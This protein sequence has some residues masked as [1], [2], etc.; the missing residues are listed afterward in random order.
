MREKSKSGGGG[1]ASLRRSASSTASD[2]V[3]KAF[4][5]ADVASVRTSLDHGVPADVMLPG[6]SALGHAAQEGHLE[7]VRLL[8]NRGANVNLAYGP[9]G[10]GTALMQACQGAQTAVVRLLIESRASIVLKTGDTILSNLIETSSETNEYLIPARSLQEVNDARTAIAKLLMGAPSSRAA[11]VE[12]HISPIGKYSVSDALYCAS[13][14]GWLWMV[15]LVLKHK[16]DV[17]YA[18]QNGA[19]PLYIACKAGMTDCASALV[20]AGA[21]P[22][23]LKAGGW[24]PLLLAVQSNHVGCVRVLIEARADLDHRIDPQEGVTTCAVMHACIA[25]TGHYESLELLLA[26]RADPDRA[27]LQTSQP[28]TALFNACHNGFKHLAVLLESYGARRH[29]LHTFPDGRVIDVDQTSDARDRGHDELSDWLLDTSDWV[30]PLHFWPMV[31]LA[32]TRAL[33]RDGWDVF[34]SLEL[35]ALWQD[36]RR[37]CHPV[38]MADAR[39]WLAGERVA[40]LWPSQADPPRPGE[41]SAV[42]AMVNEAHV[43]EAATLLVE[44]YEW[45]PRSH[46][47]FPP[48]M[49]ARAC[50]LLWLGHLLARTLENR[51]EAAAAA[52][53]AMDPASVTA[54]AL[55]PCFSAVALLDAWRDH[56]MPHALRRDE[57]GT[58]IWYCPQ[59]LPADGN[60]QR[61]SYALYKSSRRPARWLPG[62]TVELRG[63][64]SASHTHLNGTIGTSTALCPTKSGR[65]PIRTR[66]GVI[67]LKPDNLAPAGLKAFRCEHAAALEL[68]LEELG[69]DTAKARRGKAQFVYEQAAAAWRGGEHERAVELITEA[70]DAYAPEPAPSEYYVNRATLF[71]DHLKIDEKALADAERAVEL[72]PTWID[73]HHTRGAVLHNMCAHGANRWAEARASYAR[74]LAIDPDDAEVHLNLKRLAAE[75]AKQTRAKR[76]AMVPAV[77]ET[78]YQQGGAAK[79]EGDDAR[80]I[81]LYT[82]AINACA[83]DP[84]PAEYYQSRSGAL[85]R[86]GNYEEALADAD[87]AIE[88]RP[89]WGGGHA[90]RGAALSAM[91][92]HEGANRWAEAQATY[93]RLTELDPTDRD[94]KRLLV[95][96]RV[97]QA[98]ALLRDG[99]QLT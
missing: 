89:D 90:S 94:F 63:I 9:H 19:H 92:R 7:I 11:T 93:E 15:D 80:S 8:V 78:S 21:N 39:A 84:A 30:T 25:E 2:S 12:E 95:M 17:A 82:E 35:P 60:L 73:V 77:A 23:Q 31:S 79:R 74:A 18:K 49:R 13:N 34:A 96:L 20:A 62:T 52:A 86:R 76:V 83:P 42:E 37:N 98:R 85:M 50:D 22:N 70:I 14:A 69:A 3:R 57:T 81:E 24:S 91:C 51:S 32:R 58:S 53:A 65:W 55:A 64:T 48:Q 44:A 33:L 5:R 40:A 6:A 10:V 4:L 38:P 16:A 43:T 46:R 54:R 28:S 68:G 47:L 72:D 26:A 87:R 29:T 1:G 75:E 36:A 99:V 71:K 45:S 88:L 59:P 66:A 97:E 67:A 41:P 61:L 56:I 27:S